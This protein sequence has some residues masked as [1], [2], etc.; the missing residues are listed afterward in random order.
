MASQ[1]MRDHIL[2]HHKSSQ[3]FYHILFWISFKVYKQSRK[4]IQNVFLNIFSRHFFSTLCNFLNRVPVFCNSV[5]LQ[6]V[7]CLLMRSKRAQI[8]FKFFKK[9]P[10]KHRK[11]KSWMSF[12]NNIMRL[13]CITSL[14]LTSARKRLFSWNAQ[15]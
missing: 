1:E 3:L 10:L 6:P 12:W 7:E 4:F 8:Q 14:C 2:F 11:M 13:T 15:F 9:S 5:R